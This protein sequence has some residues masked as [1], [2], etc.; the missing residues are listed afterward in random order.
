MIYLKPLPF[1][2]Y[3]KNYIS[4]QIRNPALIERSYAAYCAV[5][6]AAIYQRHR[7]HVMALLPMLARI[8]TELL[9]HG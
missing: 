6:E 3:N 4:I 8:S 9:K 1:L 2:H 5:A 7:D